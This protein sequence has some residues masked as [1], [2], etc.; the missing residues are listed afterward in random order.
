MRG[1]VPP[2]PDLICLINVQTLVPADHPLRALK[3]QVDTILQRL[4]PLLQSMYAEG[5]RPSIAPERL[6]KAKLLTALYSVRSERVLCERVGYDL[7]FKWFLDM[8]PSEAPWD[9]SVFSKNQQR[10]MEHEVAALFFEEVVLLA[11]AS[12]LTSDEH[13]SVD[14]TLIE[15]WASLKSFKPKSGAPPPSDEDRGN[16]TVDF[17]GM[18]RSNATHQSRTDPE[19]R[20]VKRSSG[21]SAKLA[22]AAHALMENRHGLLMEIAVRSATEQTES[23]VALQ[24]L[25]RQR[26]QR[27][28]RP[29]SVGADKGYCNRAFVA[30]LRRGS[31]APHV[32]RIKGRKIPGLDGRTTRSCGYGLSQR[33]RKRIEEIFGWMKTVGGFRKSR[34]RGEAR[35]QQLAY[36]VGAAYNLMRIV[37]LQTAPS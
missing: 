17:H 24:L 5:G 18:R 26:R 25:E 20:L 11:R 31:I 33:V 2:Q 34:Y 27:H 3:T 15:A 32:A 36:W 12:R 9:H 35:T 23:D 8:N 37:R 16:P 22:Y 19:A 10:L 29:R 1:Q 4:S 14:S 30:A 21:E 28:L 7:L 6:L 13:F